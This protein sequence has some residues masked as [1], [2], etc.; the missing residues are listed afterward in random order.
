MGLPSLFLS[1]PAWRINNRH[2]YLAST[3]RAIS[4]STYSTTNLKANSP[5]RYNSNVHISKWCWGSMDGKKAPSPGT[6]YVSQVGLQKRRQRLPWVLWFFWLRIESRGVQAR[7]H[8][9]LHPLWPYVSDLRAGFKKRLKNLFTH[10][11]KGQING[12]RTYCSGVF[13][14]QAFY[15]WDLL[16][17]SCRFGFDV[18]L[19]MDSQI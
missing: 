9:L 15:L 3:Y 19:K 1:H 16:F 6:H 5:L 4:A 13:P 17:P 7:Q 10:Y 11:Y 12:R 14:T 8:F 18:R 2:S